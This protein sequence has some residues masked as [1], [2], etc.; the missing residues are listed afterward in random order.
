M[1]LKCS[2]HFLNDTTVRK[3]V[4]GR[5]NVAWKRAKTESE[6]LPFNVTRNTMH[7]RSYVAVQTAE[8]EQIKR[9][10][11]STLIHA[12]GAETCERRV[13][14]DVPVMLHYSIVLRALWQFLHD[15]SNA[16]KLLSI[17][18]QI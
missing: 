2:G 18:K 3:H 5:Q 7:C 14:K 12:T 13:S 6:W 10:L 4:T 15:E 11:M 1:W 8:T 9:P 17:A 16:K